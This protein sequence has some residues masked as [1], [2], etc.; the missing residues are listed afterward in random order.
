MFSSRV[1]QFRL[2]I[3]SL[4][5]F[6]L[7]FASKLG[8]LFHSFACEY[9]V[10]Q[11]HLL[12]SLSPLEYSWLPCQIFVVYTWVYFWIL[13]SVPFVCVSAFMPRSVMNIKEITF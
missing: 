10:S 4:I 8:D 5:Y 7:I 9:P 3:Y 13:G 11:P 2:Y 1:F 12:K 6:E